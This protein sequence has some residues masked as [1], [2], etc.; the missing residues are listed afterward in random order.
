MTAR[1]IGEPVSWLR[2]EQLRLGELPEP[3]RAGVA[4]HLSACEA[5]A[6]CAARIEADEA[7]PLPP[8]VVRSG[9]T[10]VRPR[11]RRGLAT[12]VGAV[13]MAAGVVL[14][15]GHAWR[16]TAP[17]DGDPTASRPKG[18]G[19]AFVLV[20][21]DGE[22]LAEARGVYRDGDRFKALVTCPPSMAG[23][24]DLVVFDADGTGRRS[25]PLEPARSLACGNE[26]PLPGALR[27]TG[28]G[29]EVVCVVWREDGDVDREALTQSALAGDPH[30]MCK[31]LHAAPPGE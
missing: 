17:A 26:V 10:E 22:R 23:H 8:L 14:A 21:D 5:C 20:R 13:A 29:G 16:G 28:T 2:L 25:F 30:A 11:P 4:Q 15:V 24:F 6:A 18:D 1:C 9:A 7:V 19:T 3:E 31:E 12:L 27:L